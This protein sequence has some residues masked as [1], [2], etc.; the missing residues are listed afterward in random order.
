MDYTANN[1]A[2]CRYCS[3]QTKNVLRRKAGCVT[4]SWCICL[5][6]TT[7][8]FFWLPFCCDGCKDT[9]FMCGQCGNIKSEIP[10]NCC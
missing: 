2:T 5:L 6:A 8:L 1:V 4:I 3:G 10:A 9:Q 7:G